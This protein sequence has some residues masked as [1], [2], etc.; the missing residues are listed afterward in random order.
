MYQ[1]AHRLL[2]ASACAIGCDAGAIQ[3]T[4]HSPTPPNAQAWQSFQGWRV[5]CGAERACWSADGPTPAW[6]RSSFAGLT[7]TSYDG[8]NF[9]AEVDLWAAPGLDVQHCAAELLW[10]V[11]A[12]RGARRDSPTR[13][14]P[15]PPAHAFWQLSARVAPAPPIFPATAFVFCPIDAAHVSPPEGVYFSTI[16]QVAASPRARDA[17]C[18]R[19]ARSQ[20]ALQDL[21]LAHRHTVTIGFACGVM[22][23]LRGR[24][25]ID[26]C[27]GDVLLA[28]DALG[29]ATHGWA[30]SSGT[31]LTDEEL[32]HFVTADS[33]ATVV[34]ADFDPAR[35]RTFD[36]AIARLGP[37][38]V[39]VISLDGMI[40]PGDPIR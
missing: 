15:G 14:E 18:A 40:Q 22:P 32:R 25:L 2:V 31:P 21:E 34:L 16:E 26:D 36:A 4:P 27:S 7:I 29:A 38:V 8:T 1:H 23:R 13:I 10:D 11:P 24:D 19:V 17:Y 39:S 33:C 3:S 12:K 30:A 5:T 6:V 28:L 37:R 20:S 35:Q 9:S